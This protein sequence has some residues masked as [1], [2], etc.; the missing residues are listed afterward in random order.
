M[1]YCWSDGKT[2]G[3][4][5]YPVVILGFVVIVF[6]YIWDAR[7]T[8]DG[9]LSVYPPAWIIIGLIYGYCLFAA[10]VSE[11]KYEI[12]A[13]GMYIKYPFAK[14][15]FHQWSEFSEIAL[16]KVHYAARSD[17]HTVA[18]RCVI[19]REESGPKHARVAK[20]SW[21]MVDYEYRHHKQIVSIYYTEERYTEFMALYPRP[22]KDYRYLRNID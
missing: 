1:R 6:G 8:P 7:P 14:K 16:C 21:S 15:K 5:I 20:E 3:G 9:K 4:R 18:I 22:I 2:L 19:G 17:A 11:R 12:T 10:W 13:D